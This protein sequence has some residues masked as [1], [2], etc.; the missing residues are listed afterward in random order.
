MFDSAHYY[1]IYLELWQ[2]QTCLVGYRLDVCVC[3]LG[4]ERQL[5]GHRLH[6]CIPRWPLVAYAHGEDS[7]YSSI[8]HV[9]ACFKLMM[10]YNTTNVV[11]YVHISCVHIGLHVATKGTHSP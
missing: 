6:A 5:V 2:L 7:R 4:F 10:Q 9:Q 1:L 3:L 11:R 8:I